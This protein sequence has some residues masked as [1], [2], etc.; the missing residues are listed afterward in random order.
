MIPKQFNSQPTHGM[1][2]HD[3]LKK[4]VLHAINVLSQ[5]RSSHNNLSSQT[6]ISDS[7]TT[8]RTIRG[9]ESDSNDLSSMHGRL[10]VKVSDSY[11]LPGEDHSNDGYHNRPTKQRTNYIGAGSRDSSITAEKPNT[12]SHKMISGSP[13]LDPSGE[14]WTVGSTDENKC[15]S[16]RSLCSSTSI[17]HRQYRLVQNYKVRW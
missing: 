12:S 17:D 7:T 5:K 15:S 10:R 11:I 6:S 14:N 1:E 8:S 9:K 16:K 4:N 3:V 2:M 13:L